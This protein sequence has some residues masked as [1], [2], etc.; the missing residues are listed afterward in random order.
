[1]SVEKNS[2]PMSVREQTEEEKEKQCPAEMQGAMLSTMFLS[3]Q[4]YNQLYAFGAA[5]AYCSN[6]N[7]K[8]CIKTKSNCLRLSSGRELKPEINPVFIPV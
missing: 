1:M 3:P 4:L 5:R 2:F 8:Y 6:N 7:N